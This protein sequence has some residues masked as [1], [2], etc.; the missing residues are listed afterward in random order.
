MIREHSLFIQV[1]MLKHQHHC[2]NSFHMA[3]NEA[4]VVMQRGYSVS[5]CM[6]TRFSVW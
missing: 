6:L 5:I 3:Y 4:I 2:L 1:A